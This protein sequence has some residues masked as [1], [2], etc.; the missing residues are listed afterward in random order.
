[1]SK[2]RPRNRFAG[3][4]R[5]R[6][7]GI[8]MLVAV[9]LVAM[10]T[11]IAASIAYEN[12]MTARKGAA[13]FA[14]DQSVLVAEA[15][16]T[17]AAWGLRQVMQADK[18]QIYLGEGWDK[19][20]GP[21]EVVPDVML[22]ASL[23]DME[24]RFNLN[25]LVKTDG[26]PDPVAVAAFEHLLVLLGIEPKWAYYAVDWIDQDSVPMNPEGA[27]DSVYLG[28]TPPY[29]AAN[30]YITSASELLALPGFGHERYQ[31]LAPFVTALPTDAKV[32]LCT[33]L[34][35]V[36]DAYLP[37]GRQEFS[38]D[39]EGLQ[40]NRLAA[41]GCFPKQAD[42]QAAIGNAQQFDGSKFEQVSHYFKLTSYITIGTTEFNLYSLMLLD[43]T[44]NTA[45]PILR[46]YT[47][48]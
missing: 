31:K 25:S 24:G 20:Q 39:P 3:P 29:H 21:F 26:T 48:D 46:S 34:P 35:Q 2:P 18:T 10:G 8:A 14:F 43:G 32:N 28:Q 41:G 33:A 5:S 15:A 37:A 9:L 13:T 16:E 30:M 23:E 12:A 11:I 38:T 1:M 36:L 40:K 22:T 17:L 42:Y 19:P 6:Q 47:P 7:R 27:E 45:R 44:G 4:L